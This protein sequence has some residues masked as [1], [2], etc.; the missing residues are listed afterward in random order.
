MRLYC[1]ADE[2]TV[3]GF[4]IAG[5]EGRAV[6]SAAAAEAAVAE[7]AGRADC[8]LIVLT[9]DVAES[10]RA[11]VEALRHE[12]ARPLVVEIPGPGGSRAGHRALRRIAQEAVGIPLGQGE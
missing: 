9:Q 6:D 4:R 3:R 1:I 11:R 7:A 2:D 5:I 10:I 8:G 12:R